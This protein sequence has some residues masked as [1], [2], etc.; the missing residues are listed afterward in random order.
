MSAPVQNK[1]EK[2]DKLDDFNRNQ[3]HV[4]LG[5]RL[6]IFGE[7]AGERGLYPLQLRSSWH[8]NNITLRNT[9]DVNAFNLPFRQ[10]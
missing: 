8:S 2:K 4:H 7:T 6:L 10:N 5:P 3:K 9:E 1:M